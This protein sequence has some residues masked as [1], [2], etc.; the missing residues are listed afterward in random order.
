MCF[1]FR[2]SPFFF[3]F[4]PRERACQIVYTFD[5]DAVYE[6]LKRKMSQPK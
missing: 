1:V 5:E 3:P 2:P 4:R 6:C